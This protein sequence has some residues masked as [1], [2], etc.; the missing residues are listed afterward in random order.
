MNGGRRPRIP[1]KGG[2]EYDVFTVWR[3]FCCRAQRAGWTND[4]KRSYRRRER[5]TAKAEAKVERD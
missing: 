5:R 4:V 1:L 2:D 3:H